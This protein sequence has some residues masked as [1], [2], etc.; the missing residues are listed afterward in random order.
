MTYVN[1]KNSYTVDGVA[2]LLSNTV[3]VLIFFFGGKPAD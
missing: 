3:S 2:I 1:I